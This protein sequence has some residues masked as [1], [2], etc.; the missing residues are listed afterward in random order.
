MKERNN[1]T[2]RERG[3]ERE[4]ERESKRDENQFQKI[5]SKKL[6]FFTFCDHPQLG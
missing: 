5:I 6:T 4:R 1:E 3:R 2:G